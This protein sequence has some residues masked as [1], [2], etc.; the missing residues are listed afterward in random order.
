MG[1]ICII[2]GRPINKG[3]AVLHMSV[4]NRSMEIRQDAK[5][6]QAGY[7]DVLLDL[8][9]RGLV[10][11]RPER[12]ANNFAETGVVSDPNSQQMVS[13]QPP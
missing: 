13:R 2:R 4:Q 8:S 9:K 1:N 10:H 3:F 11:Q 5:A 6:W 7:I 12:P